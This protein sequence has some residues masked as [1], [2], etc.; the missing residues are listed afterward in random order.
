[1][2]GVALLL[3]V[4]TD[5]F[6]SAGGFPNGS[7]FLLRLSDDYGVGNCAHCGVLSDLSDFF[8]ETGASEGILGK[9]YEAHL[10]WKLPG[11][12]LC[13]ESAL[14]QLFPCDLC[15]LHM[16]GNGS[17]DSDIYNFNCC[18]DYTGNSYNKTA[19]IN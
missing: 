4:S 14:F 2:D 16:C 17:L 19:Y 8:S 13:T 3:L 12:E 10:S 1:M 9:F 6:L 7:I 11:V 18:Y 5:C 15:F